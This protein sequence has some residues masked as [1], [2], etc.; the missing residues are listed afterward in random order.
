MF[1]L[2]F[3]RFMRENFPTIP[4]Y[5]FFIPAN[6]PADAYCFENAGSGIA[7]KRM[8]NDDIITRSIKLTFSTDDAIKL[9]NDYELT[10]Y[11]ERCHLIGDMSVL[12]ARIINFTDRYHS[13]Q[14]IFER[15]YTI[16][17]KYKE[18]Q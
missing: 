8:D 17:F 14:K 9:F 6:A 7:T 10:K 18:T 3:L 4:T 13:D 5:S 16:N 12:N 2:N 1:E 11:I 15:I